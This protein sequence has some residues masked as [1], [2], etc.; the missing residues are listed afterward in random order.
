M[1]KSLLKIRAVSFFYGFLS[2]LGLALVGVLSSQEFMSLVKENFGQTIFTSFLFLLL[3]ELIKHGRNV[4][5]VK[6]LGSKEKPEDF[7]LI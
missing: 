1:D 6:K 2:L 5:E 4:L 7:F 3:P